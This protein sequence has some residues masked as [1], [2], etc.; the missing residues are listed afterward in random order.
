MSNVDAIAAALAR[1]CGPLLVTLG[2]S[3]LLLSPAGGGVGL[4][5]GLCLAL[6][7]GLHA[8]V[9]GVSASRRAFPP[10]LMRAAL[11]AGLTAAALGAEFVQSPWS[12]RLVEA[13]LFA[14]TASGVILVFE[15]LFGRA[16][17]LRDDAW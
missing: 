12:A 6:G 11:C 16:A 13:G 2:V 17:A 1:L 14:V 8:L 9:F 4:V 5:A 7:A 10:V 15:T 3:M